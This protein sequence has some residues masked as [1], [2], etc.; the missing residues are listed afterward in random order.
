MVKATRVGLQRI[1]DP[2]KCGMVVCPECHDTGYVQYPKR[3]C[4]PKCRGFGWIK[5]ETFKEQGKTVF[6]T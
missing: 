2:E 4:C 3:Q 1:D 5:K 6:H